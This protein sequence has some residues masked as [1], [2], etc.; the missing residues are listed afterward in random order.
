MN[1]GR[2]WR[3]LGKARAGSLR[4]TLAAEIRARASHESQNFGDGV[5]VGGTGIGVGQPGD[6][7]LGRMEHRIVAC[8]ANELGQRNA[9]H[10]FA[11]PRRERDEAGEGSSGSHGWCAGPTKRGAEQL[12]VLEP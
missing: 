6:E 1:S 10:R 8:S 5:P 12:S 7:E 2:R 3:T 4:L 11:A 9:Q